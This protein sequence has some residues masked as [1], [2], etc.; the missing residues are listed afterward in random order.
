MEYAGGA[1]QLGW[2]PEDSLEELKQLADTAGAEVVAKFLQK[3]PKPDPAFFIGRGKVQE[4]ALYV[5]Q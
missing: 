5:Q 2:T 1:S 4:L 3:R